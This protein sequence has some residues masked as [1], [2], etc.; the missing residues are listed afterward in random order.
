MPRKTE[1]LPG[2][3]G[4]FCAIVASLILVAP[5]RPASP[6][7]AVLQPFLPELGSASLV[8]GAGLLA[9]ATLALPR[10]LAIAL[11][12][13]AGV[14]LTGTAEVTFPSDCGTCF[15]VDLPV[16]SV[17]ASGRW[18]RSKLKVRAGGVV[19]A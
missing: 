5:D 6:T 8:A 16:G 15:P 13:F 1:A 18:V 14:A 7:Y 19:D 10:W 2:V 12:V 3:V 4:A 11:R 9:T 17:A